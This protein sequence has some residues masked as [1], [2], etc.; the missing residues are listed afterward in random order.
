M[1]YYIINNKMNTDEKNDLEKIRTNDYHVF[2]Y[3]IIL[4]LLPQLYN[5]LE[6]LDDIEKPL[7]I[8]WKSI[9][10]IIKDYMNNKLPGAPYDKYIDSKSQDKINQKINVIVWHCAMLKVAEIGQNDPLLGKSELLQNIYDFID[11]IYNIFYDLTY[12]INLNIRDINLFHSCAEKKASEMKDDNSYHSSEC[13]NISNIDELNNILINNF[14]VSNQQ[15]ETGD[16][17]NDAIQQA[18]KK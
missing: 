18:K 5:E 13:F 6:N 16:F 8:F 9:E 10:L 7:T 17:I 3:K 15:Y 11:E 14:G 4:G 12:Q 1:Y 2:R